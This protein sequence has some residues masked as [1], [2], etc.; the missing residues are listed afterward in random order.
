MKR[1][2]INPN[3]DCVLFYTGM[4]CRSSAQ[5]KNAVRFPK[6]LKKTLERWTPQKCYEALTKTPS[7]SSTTSF[8]HVEIVKLVVD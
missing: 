3:K 6:D 8:N 4:G 2:D 7:V 1:L 5:E